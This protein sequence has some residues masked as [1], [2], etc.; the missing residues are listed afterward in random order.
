MA[1]DSKKFFWWRAFKEVGTGVA[2][3]LFI[4]LLSGTH[5]ITDSKGPHNYLQYWPVQLLE[6]WPQYA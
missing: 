1:F 6:R 4:H 5:F 2:G 3:D